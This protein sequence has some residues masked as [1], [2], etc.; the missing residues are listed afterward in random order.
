VSDYDQ[1]T[2]DSIADVLATNAGVA[3]SAVT[4]TITSASVRV[5]AEIEVADEQAATSTATTLASGIFSNPSALTSALASGGVSGVTVGQIETLPEVSA[6]PNPG[7]GGTQSGDGG[8]QPG[9]GGTAPG[10][11]GTQP[12]GG[13]TQP[14]GGGTGPAPGGPHCAG[15]PG[16]ETNNDQG[17]CQ[18]A[19]GCNWN[20]GAP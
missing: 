8:T 4:L 12:G 9:G 10:G 16:C 13:G 2:Q 7:G 1:T 3:R 18:A 6:P 11:G 14:G 17:T 20:T 19:A 5:I 15:Q